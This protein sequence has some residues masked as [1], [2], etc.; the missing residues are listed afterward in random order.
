MVFTLF[1]KLLFFCPLQHKKN[2]KGI[3]ID[4]KHNF[5]VN[6]EGINDLVFSQKVLSTLEAVGVIKK[7]SVAIVFGEALWRAL[8]FYE[9]FVNPIDCLTRKVEDKNS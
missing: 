4:L 5:V 3:V 8:S 7:Y 6:L 1:E 9:W 2:L